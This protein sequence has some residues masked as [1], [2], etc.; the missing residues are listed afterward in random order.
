MATITTRSGKGS[1]LTNNE[2]DANFTNLNTDKLETSGGTL[3]GDLNFGDNDKAIFGAGNDLQIFHSGSDSYINETGT[4]NLNIKASNNLYLM[5]GSSELYAKFTTDGAATLY[6]NNAAKLATTS[7]GIDVTGDVSLG[8]NGKAKFGAGNDLQ[9]Y[10]SGSESR[11]D[12]NGAGNLKI[13][14]DNLEIYNS[15]SSEAKA[16]FNTNGSVQ[17]YYDNAEKLATTSTGIDVTGTVS[18]DGL[19]VDGNAV[20]NNA[21]NAT[22]QLQAT[23]GNAYQLRTDVNDVFIYNAT[24][25]RSLAKFAYGGDI[26]FY[27]DTGTTPKFFWDASAESLGIGTSSPTQ[28][29]DISGGHLRLDDAYRIRFGGGTAAIEG[30]GSSNILSL[31]TNNTERLRIDSSGKW[32]LVLVRHTGDGTVF[33]THSWL[34]H[35]ST[36]TPHQL[37]HRFS[38]LR[39]F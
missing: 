17:L 8:D 10:H 27:E 15:A 38:N 11:I 13:N 3:T 30:S 26:S 31:I 35:A 32:V 33:I 9:I 29:L 4:G 36:L 6:H 28:K 37:N 19:T 1:P 22:L 24:G 20:V 7:T 25:A 23:G 34:G 16:K 5:S 18:A 21:T 14:A 39:W 12:E 2:V